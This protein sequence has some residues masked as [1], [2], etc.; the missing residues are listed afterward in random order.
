[1]GIE[2]LVKIEVTRRQMNRNLAPMYGF[3]TWWNST[4]I[5][6]PA[7][8]QLGARLER[9]M[10]ECSSLERS[11]V[12]QDVVCQQREPER[13]MASGLASRLTTPS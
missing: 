12:H 1:M 10:P 2:R 5:C 3:K 4:P 13:A 9:L 6:R 11:R 8:S 7:W